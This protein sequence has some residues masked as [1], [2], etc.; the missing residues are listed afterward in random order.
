MSSETDHGIEENPVAEPG[1]D[2]DNAGKGLAKIGGLE[3]FLR[4]RTIGQRVWTLVG[5]GVIGVAAMAIT[6]GGLEMAL[7]ANE[8]SYDSYAE[9]ERQNEQLIIATLQMRRSEKD[10]LLRRAEKYEAKYAKAAGRAQ[11][12]VKALADIP[13]ARPVEAELKAIAAG[14]AS[15]RAQFATVFGLQNELGLDEKSGLQGSLRKA[16]HGVET[17]LK[18]A[19]LDAL[20]VKMLMMRRHEKDFIMRSAEKY[21]GRIDKRQAE[22]RSILAASLLPASEQRAINAL[23]DTYVANFKKFAA[24]SLLL[25]AETKKLSTIFAGMVPPFDA[26]HEFTAAKMTEAG[27]D[28]QAMKEALNVFLIGMVAAILLLSIA[29]GFLVARSITVPVRRFSE[30]VDQLAEGNTELEIDGKEY[31]DEIGGMAR[32]LETFRENLKRDAERREEETRQQEAEK[33]KLEEAQRDAEQQAAEEKRVAD[34][35]AET[36]RQQAMLRMADEFEK[37][38]MGVVSSVASATDQMRSSAEKMSATAQKTS[39][40]ATTVAAGAE[41]ATSNVQTVASATEELSASVEEISRQVTHSNEI[42][43][44]AVAGAQ[45]TNKKVEGL[46]EGAQKIGD[47][48]S[49]INDIASQTNLLALNATIEA[50]RAG[51]AGKGFAVVA[52]E[53]KSLADQTAKATEEIGT[54]IGAIQSATEDAVQAIQGIG[55][56]IVEIGEIATSVVAAVGEQGAATREIAENVQQAAAG[57]QDVSTAIADVTAVAAES[58]TV[59]GQMLD[60]ATSLGQQG[61]T[62]RSEVQ[63]FLDT[64]RAA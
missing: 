57:T 22:F 52:T 46:A 31:R 48:I 45:E 13:N 64:V 4:N 33:R 42:A 30:T 44:N 15:H 12:T 29:G 23:L 47:V 27:A 61:E 3:R 2:S 49:L 39:E 40:Q 18:T 38:V 11:A 17:R 24:K 51:E 55:G 28:R 56:T 34:A 63:K 26:V 60:A 35:K 41:E 8:A 20:T 37:N 53:V 59:S 16:V 50:A 10:F 5:A 58:M 14:L 9:I 32:A 6:A 19:N 43:Q 62:L 21:I 7:D 25:K 54:Q 1:N 36:E